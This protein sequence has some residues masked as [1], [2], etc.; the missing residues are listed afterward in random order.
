MYYI[1]YYLLCIIIIVIV[2]I[3]IA[4]SQTQLYVWDGLK[5]PTPDEPWGVEPGAVPLRPFALMDQQQALQLMEERDA[6]LSHE[7]TKT[8]DWLQQRRLYHLGYWGL[9]LAIVGI[10]NY[11]PTS[12]MG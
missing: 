4:Y 1:M 9:L 12:T 8:V 7:K 2:P 5:P 10:H 3:K 6:E 11:E